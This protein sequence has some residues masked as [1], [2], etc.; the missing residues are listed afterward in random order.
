MPRA[1]IAT[2]EWNSSY[3]S[4]VPSFSKPAT[5]TTALR[6]V[7]MRKIM[8]RE[9]RLGDV[10]VDNHYEVLTQGRAPVKIKVSRIEHYRCSRADTHVNNNACYS[11]HVPVWVL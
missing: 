10:I 3:R 2:S 5:L 4:M 11:H 9:L 7:E 6:T 1:E 8:P